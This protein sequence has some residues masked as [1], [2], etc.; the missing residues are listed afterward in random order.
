MLAVTAAASPIQQHC[1]EKAQ[2]R[3]LFDGLRFYII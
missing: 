3:S 1:K 2:D